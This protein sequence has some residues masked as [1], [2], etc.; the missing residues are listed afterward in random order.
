MVL[1]SCCQDNEIRLLWP[2]CESF[3]C[4]FFEYNPFQTVPRYSIEENETH[5]YKQFFY[6]HMFI[7]RFS[8]AQSSVYENHRFRRFNRENLL[9]CGARMVDTPRHHQ[10]RA[11]THRELARAWDDQ[12]VFG[13]E[14]ARGSSRSR[15][16]SSRNISTSLACMLSTLPALNKR[17][18]SFS[19]PIGGA[20]LLLT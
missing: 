7:K 1:F 9:Q 13:R 14:C 8:S 19:I 17:A 6:R 10:P 20:F 2:N 15:G 3:S 16:E 5:L 18:A 11:H 12:N 4:Q